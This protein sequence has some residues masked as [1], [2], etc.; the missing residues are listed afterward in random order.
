[1]AKP[2]KTKSPAAYPSLEQYTC[3]RRSFLR[4]LVFGAVAAGVGGRI[5]SACTSTTSIDGRSTMPDLHTVRSPGSGFASAWIG[6]EE[7]L[8]Y[9]VTFT[10]YDEEFA[11]FYRSNEDQALI[12]FSSILSGYSCDDF[13]GSMT[14][15][16]TALA[17]AL[18]EHYRGLFGETSD[19]VHSLEILVEECEWM[20]IAGDMEEPG[21]P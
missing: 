9:A 15:V 8:R 21:Y 18:E 11:E 12:V 6:T 5:L 1:M 3:E 13:S 4:R 16:R 20:P 14:A 2:Q 17:A 7:Y 10:T 19:L